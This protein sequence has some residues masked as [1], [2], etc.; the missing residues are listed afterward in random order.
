VAQEK[1][2][3]K[4]KEN[5]ESKALEGTP[6]AAANESDVKDNSAADALKK[7]KDEGSV[8]DPQKLPSEEKLVKRAQKD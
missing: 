4:K 5:S 2:D 1:K 3:E 6:T 7:K 8:E